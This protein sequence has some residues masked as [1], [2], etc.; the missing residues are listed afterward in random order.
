MGQ[1]DRQTDGQVNDG[2]DGKHPHHLGSPGKTA[3]KWVCVSV[4]DSTM[5]TC[6][7]SHRAALSMLRQAGKLSTHARPTVTFPAVDH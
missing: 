3:V 5:L 1:T 6:R 4:C 7:E 2:M